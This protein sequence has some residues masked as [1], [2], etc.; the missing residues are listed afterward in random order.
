MH[1]KWS[2][3]KSN[4]FGTFWL[5][6]IKIWSWKL[7]SVN[8]IHYRIFYEFCPLFSADWLW[9]ASIYLKC[10]LEENRGKNHVVYTFR[11]KKKICGSMIKDPEGFY[12][13]QAAA[14]EKNRTLT[15]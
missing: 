5:A 11:Q 7:E 14:I 2:E 15:E 10:K 12:T 8:I 13:S 6:G 3:E 1:D 9:L 4:M